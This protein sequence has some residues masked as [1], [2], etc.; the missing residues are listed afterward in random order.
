MKDSLVKC[1]NCGREQKVN[2]GHCLKSG[3]P[4]CCGYT[5]ALIRTRAKIDAAVGKIVA[6][7]VRLAKRA[8]HLAAGEQT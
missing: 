8:A 5:M 6:P 3:W 7:A 2:F 1:D 4:E